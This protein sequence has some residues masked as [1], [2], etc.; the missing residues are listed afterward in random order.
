MNDKILMKEIIE[1]RKLKGSLRKPKYATRKLSI[2]LVSCMLGFSLIVSPVDTWA[3]EADFQAGLEERAN[4]ESSEESIFSK[5]QKQKLLDAKFTEE[6][7]KDLENEAKEKKADEGV[8]FDLDEF[9][10][11][12]IADKERQGEESSD[13]ED[14]DLEFGDEVKPEA[15]GEHNDSGEEVD[16]LSSATYYNKANWENKIKDKSRWKVGDNQ[17][18]VRVTTSEPV[19]MNDIDYDG[20]FVDANGRT[21]LRMVYKEKGGAATGVWYRAIFNFGDLDQYIDYDKSYMVGVN[22]AGNEAK[23]GKLDP[24][25]KG[26]E[27]IV[28]LGVLRGD[29][30]NQRKNLPINLV[31]KEDVTIEKLPK[32]NYIVQ[33]RLADTQGK[34]IYA[35]APKGTSM[36]YS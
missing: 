26:K 31:L 19:Q 30:T 2:G 34:K 15:V 6:E 12:A 13:K 21:V 7:I 5:E 11:K 14:Q 23:T 24:F 27:R 1:Q 16:A 28:D 32:K 18:L 35:Y 36:D 9:I 20:N 4:A 22:I 29:L 25:N 17:T 3:E 33:M 10:D 8:L